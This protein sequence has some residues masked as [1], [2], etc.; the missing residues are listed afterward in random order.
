MNTSTH[1]VA[2]QTTD[3][4]NNTTSATNAQNVGKR[5][6]T[7]TEESKVREALTILHSVLS[8]VGSPGRA[9]YTIPALDDMSHK[10][11]EHLLSRTLTAIVEKDAERYAELV[12]GVPAAFDALAQGKRDEAN[13]VVAEF[14]SLSPAIRALVSDKIP[15]TITITYPEIARIFPKGASA[16]DIQRGISDMKVN[17]VSPK[18]SKKVED[19][20][21]KLP[22]DPTA[23]TK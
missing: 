14:A 20:Y 2:S 9:T 13:V 12:K 8:T 3:T 15:T 19:M 4:H 17:L 16:S 7:P 22:L 23:A 5:T 21:V 10:H 18:G 1:T 11:T 6:L